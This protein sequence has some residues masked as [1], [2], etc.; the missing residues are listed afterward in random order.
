V[1]RVQK[2]LGSRQGLERIV[3]FTDAVVAI[4]ITLLILPLSESLTALISDKN[5]KTGADLVGLAGVLFHGQYLQQLLGLVISFVVI[6]RLWWAHHQMFE[7]VEAYTGPLVWVNLFWAFTIVFLPLPTSFVAFQDV[8]ASG[9]VG[10]FLVYVGTM[11]IS[12]V[13][14]M[15]L[16]GIIHF[17]PRL[18][19]DHGRTTRNRFIGIA[20]TSIGFIGALVLGSLD[21]TINYW[22]LWLIGLVSIVDG[23]VD[24]WF[25]RRDAKRGAKPAAA[26]S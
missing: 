1:A 17:D 25:D 10:T 13:L 4:A 16:A 22:S 18:A 2:E 5:T 26:A 11:T 24:R 15:V 23:Q 20:F 7:H 8:H 19:E 3:F 9:F 14:L 12:A 21:P 6:A